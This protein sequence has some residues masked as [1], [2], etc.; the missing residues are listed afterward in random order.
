MLFLCV[1]KRVCNTLKMRKI[2]LFL[3]ES[4]VNS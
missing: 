4:L 2:R 1:N 3:D